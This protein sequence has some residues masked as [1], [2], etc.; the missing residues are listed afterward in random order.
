MFGHLIEALKY[1]YPPEGGIAFGIDRIIMLMCGA[2]SIREVIAFPKTQTG[3][4]PLVQ[5]P[6]KVSEEQLKELEIKTTMPQVSVC[7]ER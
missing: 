4:C 1:G 2:K 7:E 6:S 5:A 3:A